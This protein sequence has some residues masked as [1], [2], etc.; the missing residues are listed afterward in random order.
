MQKYLDYT[1]HYFF[2]ASL[3]ATKA[4]GDYIK[5][6]QIKKWVKYKNIFIKCDV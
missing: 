4:K 3:S 6:M 1:L 5:Q 2:C